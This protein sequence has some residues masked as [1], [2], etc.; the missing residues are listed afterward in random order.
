MAKT[1]PLTYKN[2]NR[3]YYVPSDYFFEHTDVQELKNEYTRIRDILRKRVNRLEKAGI[4]SEREI[5]KL[6]SK[7]PKISELNATNSKE[8]REALKNVMSESSHLLNRGRITLPEA[9]KKKAEYTQAMNDILAREFPDIDP[10]EYKNIDPFT[11]FDF[12][13]YTKDNTQDGAIYWTTSQVRYLF[14]VEGLMR[15]S[16][17]YEE[18]NKL[19]AELANRIR[20]YQEIQGKKEST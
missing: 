16:Q 15:A 3:G 4:M 10:K 18:D 7:F 8:M 9:R 13:D 17:S 5:E 20:G 19:F 12:L 14:D 2:E 1:T 6:R 11:F